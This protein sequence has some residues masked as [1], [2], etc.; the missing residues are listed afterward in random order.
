[1]NSV[2]NRKEMSN[3]DIEVLFKNH[4][5]ALADSTKIQLLEIEMNNSV[6]LYDYKNALEIAEKIIAFPTDLS[7]EEKMDYENNRTIFNILKNVPKQTIS[8]SETSLPI[9]KDIAGLSRIPVKL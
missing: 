1:L 9:T 4:N 7:E 6:L 8:I 2:F 3:S 5:N